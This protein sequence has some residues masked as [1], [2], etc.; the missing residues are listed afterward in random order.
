MEKV[1]IND[2]AKLAGVSKTTVSFYLNGKLDKMSK[3][4]ESK[5]T[6]VIEKT[7]YLPSALARSLSYK[8]T[9]L[10]GVIIGDIT[11][12]FANQIVKGI[13]D[14]GKRS[15]YQMLVSSSNYDIQ[16]EKKIVQGMLSLGVD[17][18]IV[19]PTRSFESMWEQLNFTKPIVYFDSPNHDTQ[20]YWVKTNNYE[21]VYE[22]CLSLVDRGY[23]EFVLISADPNVLKTR[24][25]RYRGF[26]DSLD[27]KKKP[28]EIILASD[29][30]TEDELIIKLSKYKD[31]KHP[32]CFFA[33]NNWLLTKVYQAMKHQHMFIG[34]N[35]GLIGFD[36][37]EWTE[38]VVPSI[39]TIVQPAFE[40]GQKAASILIDAIEEK[41]LEVPNQILRCRVNEKQSTQI[42]RENTIK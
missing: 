2:I 28:Y 17:G 27:Y 37:L 15:G 40:E 32:V 4:T 42:K 8:K 9:N 33:C 41:G 10:I 11:N 5:I 39:T 35:C 3:E 23:E 25:E 30:T 22:T 13:E 21:A 36:S 20:G 12:S 31:R 24:L 34:D 6:K 1:T 19:Q 7:N 14:V 26:T 18:L 16:N 38:L 29:S